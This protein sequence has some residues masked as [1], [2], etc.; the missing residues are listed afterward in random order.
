MLNTNHPA[1]DEYK[2]QIGTNSV[3]FLDSD[4]V[5]SGFQSYSVSPN[6]SYWAFLFADGDYLEVTVTEATGQL[7]QTFTTDIP[8]SDDD[9]SFKTYALDNGSVMVRSDI[10]FFDLYNINGE[11]IKNISAVFG[12]PDGEG[13]ANVV[14]SKD[15]S[16]IYFYNA[17][18]RFGN[19]T[20]SRVLRFNSNGEPVAIFNSESKSIEQVNV[21]PDGNKILLL[22][23]DGSGNKSAQLIDSKGSVVRSFDFDFEPIELTVSADQNFMT[24]RATGRVVVYRLDNGE[25]LGAASIRQRTIAASYIPADN[26]IVVLAG[27]RN[28][29]TVNSVSVHVINISE[30]SISRGEISQSFGYHGVNQLSVYALRNSLYV[31]SGLNQ[32][33]VVR[34]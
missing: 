25:R 1:Q 14:M 9:P 13:L 5:I 18:I 33:L 7:V 6:N 17:E 15:G 10:A 3:T 22:L 16:G 26:T 28:G 20:G 2:I 31:I 30:R 4:E 34:L 24:S 12:G 11:R 32:N 21:L 23:S 8:V 19:N 29:N 27:S